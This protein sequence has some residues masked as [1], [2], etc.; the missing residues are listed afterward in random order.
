M[1]NGGMMNILGVNVGKWWE[2]GGGIG[3][4]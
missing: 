4:F 2:N 1:M 3:V